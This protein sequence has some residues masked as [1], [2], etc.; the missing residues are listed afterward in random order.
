MWVCVDGTEGAGKTTVTTG[1]L[2]ALSAVGINEFSD[3]RFGEA[4]RNA[5]QASPHFISSSPIGQ[6]LVFLGDFMELYESKVEPALQRG[7]TVITD[8]GWLSKYAYQSAVLQTVMT[9]ERAAG[10][11]DVIMAYIPRPDLTVLLTAPAPAIRARLIKRDGDCSDDRLAF[12]RRAAAEAE[13]FAARA[14]GVRIVLVDAARPRHAVLSE[15]LAVV[16]AEIAT[17][18]SAGR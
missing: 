9:P 17:R 2:A 6:S 3:T 11:L 18:P 10:L 5:V 16:N 13:A 14:E 15:A 7:E 12:I 8:R 4:L 1:L